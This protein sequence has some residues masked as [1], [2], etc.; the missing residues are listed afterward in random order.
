MPSSFTPDRRLLNP[1][2]DGYKFQPL[3]D[4][5]VAARHAL[6][7]AHRP[8]QTNVSGRAAL[9][10]E[11]VRSRV[12]HNHLAV[13]PAGAPRAAYVDAELRVI[14]ID[15][16][17]VSLLVLGL[18]LSPCMWGLVRRCCSWLTPDLESRPRSSP[19]FACC[20][21]SQ[22][23]FS[24][25][26][27]KRSRGSTPPPFSSTERPCS[28]P[29][30]MDRS[31]RSSSATQVLHLCVCQSRSQRRPYTD[32]RSVEFPSE[33]TMSHWRKDERS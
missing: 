31:M 5:A 23:R 9:S 16:D 26:A 25:T 18:S 8:S 14:G 19:R 10:F 2:F 17:E 30:D 21:S 11:E 28:S 1:H 20:M 33:Y 3:E 6:P 12:R 4:D 24:L 22:A 15:V 13:C 7:P 32:L 29:M 27:S